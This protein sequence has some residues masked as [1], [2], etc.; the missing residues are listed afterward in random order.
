[1]R[2]S[3]ICD[4][5]TAS[6]PFKQSQVSSF[7][8]TCP[9]LH[10][11]NSTFLNL[12]PSSTHRIVPRD[13]YITWAI[14]PINQG[15]LKRNPS[16]SPKEF[17]DSWYGRHAQLVVPFFL[18]SGVTYYAQIHAPLSTKLSDLD[19]S[20]FSGA[21]EMPSEDVL[22]I[23]APDLPMPKWKK[24]YYEEVILVD[25]KRLLESLATEHIV[26]V[27]EGAVSGE[28]RVIIQAGK[29]VIQVEE[30][31]WEVW[32]GYEQRGKQSKE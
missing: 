8:P 30:G 32:R 7:F 22:K 27:E 16:L 15:L 24:E 21:A 13:N 29:S 14:M 26:Q 4:V 12:N 25:E 19:L 20:A 6:Q 3:C 1:M 5:F 17:S 11:S 23:F 28:K 2:S 31:I 9:L 18:H 10:T